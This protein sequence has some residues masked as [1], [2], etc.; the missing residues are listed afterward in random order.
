MQQLLSTKARSPGRDEQASLSNITVTKCGGVRVSSPRARAVDVSDSSG[1][2]TPLAHQ[3]CQS[4]LQQ[5]LDAARREL[6]RAQ[7]RADALKAELDAR[8]AD[9]DSEFLEIFKESRKPYPIARRQDG[10]EHNELPPPPRVYVED[11]FVRW[12]APWDAARGP[13]KPADFT[14]AV[15]TSASWADPV[16]CR[17]VR[18]VD[19]ERRQKKAFRALDYDADGRPRNPIGRTGLRGRGSLA[20]WGPNFASD[21]VVTRWK[22]GATGILEVL[23]NPHE[24]I[25]G[26]YAMLGA[27]QRDEDQKSGRRFAQRALDKL[28]DGLMHE[29]SDVDRRQLEA[30][31]EEHQGWRALDSGY[32]DDPRATDNAWVES[33]FHHLHLDKDMLASLH[34]RASLD[35]HLPL[36][37][38]TLIEGEPEL[39]TLLGNHCRMAFAAKARML[40]PI[41]I[42][43]L[44]K[45]KLVALEPQA[46]EDKK[47]SLPPN[48][49][50]P[51]SARSCTSQGSSMSTTFD[52]C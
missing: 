47:S 39:Q 7:A 2:S 52:G 13:Y 41:D 28:V 24:T 15:V 33:T 3:Q 4:S 46:G 22:P 50:C 9:Q 5:E 8:R 16:D 32:V 48:A 21:I 49:S 29:V 37:W 23:A 6:A 11:A 26:V 34:V 25:D 18:D 36:K 10:K 35:V 42:Q 43:P 19:W 40:P 44:R 1:P 20:Q 27:M 45:S 51:A 14:T 30:S 38:I 31:F 17:L 12:S